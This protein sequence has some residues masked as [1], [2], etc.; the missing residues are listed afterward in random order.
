MTFKRFK[1]TKNHI[2]LLKR[3]YVSWDDCE[4][5][6]P[7][8]DPKRPY[9]NS[10]V[11]NDIHEILTGESIG[12]T[13][14]KRDELTQKED[15]NYYKLHQEMQTVLQILLVN[16]KIKPGIYE[17]DEYSINWKYKKDTKENE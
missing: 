5:G 6:A 13:N 1:V 4:F 10:S 7:C 14:S 15:E 16:L 2:K 12:C 9:G 3:M 17:A 8:I 11:T